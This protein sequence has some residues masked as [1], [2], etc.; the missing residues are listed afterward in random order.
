MARAVAFLSFLL[1]GP[2]LLAGCTEDKGPSDAAGGSDAAP[3]APAGA[4]ADDAPP[5]DFDAGIP[6]PVWSIGD[7]WQ[8]QVDY[9]SGESYDTKIVVYDEDD[10]TLFV[11]AEDRELQLRAGITHYPTLGAVAKTTLNGFI[12]GT[13]VSFLRFPMQNGTWEGPYRDFTGSYSTTYALLPTPRGEVPGFITTMND[14]ADGS[15]R[16]RHGWSPVTK[17]FTDF[18]F[19]FDGVDPP[20]VVFT[21]QDWGSGYNGTLPVVELVDRIH[22]VFPALGAAPPDPADP[23]GSVPE[24]PPA[25]PARSTAARHAGR[26]V[27]RGSQSHRRS[28]ESACSGSPHERRRSP[29]PRR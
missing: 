29:R 5:F 2:A 16:F 26:D 10:S 17:W 25:A 11:T 3:T 7:W 23:Q 28:Q 27:V 1:L 19:D 21:L 4:G 15:F 6:V 13:E 22:R 14:S 9:S 12:H 20:D 24:Q 8:Y 18:T